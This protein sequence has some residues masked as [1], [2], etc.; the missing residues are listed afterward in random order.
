MTRYR[1]VDSR[2]A[3]GFPVTA[4]CT[5]AGVSSSSYYEWCARVASGPT[6][7]EASEAH[8]VNAIHTIH[9]LSGGAYGAPMVH[10]EL[11]HQGWSVNR[12]RVERLS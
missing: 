11:R 6:D 9:D 5:V 8:L 7:R 2:T 1:W 3:E 10:A 12:K 4:A